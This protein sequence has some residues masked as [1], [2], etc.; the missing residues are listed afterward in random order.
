MLTANGQTTESKLDVLAGKTVE[1]VD[2]SAYY[3]ENETSAVKINFT[4]GT[5]VLLK[6]SSVN[7]D[8]YSSNPIIATSLGPRLL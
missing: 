5:Y 6:A 4:D 7:F 1:S 8:Q 2:V 3:S